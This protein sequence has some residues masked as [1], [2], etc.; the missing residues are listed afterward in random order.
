VVTA[1]A[2]HEDDTVVVSGAAGGVGVLAVQLARREGADVLGI[3]S[4]ANADWLA[5][6]GIRPVAYGEGLADRLHAAAPGG[7]DAWLDLY[8][9]GYV[10]LAV[11]LGVPVERI[12]TIID[13]AAAG[14]TGARTVFGADTPGAP[15]LTRLA[16]LAA[17]GALDVPVRTFP[18][19]RVRDAYRELEKRHTRGKIV[20]VP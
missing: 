6:H 17:T 1:V 20:L 15:A 13:F 8:G 14:R 19:D 2:P 16:E 3:A 5:E 10:D 9:D 4:E 7:M 12:V 11:S 18:L